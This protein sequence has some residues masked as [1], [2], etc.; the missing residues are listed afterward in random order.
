MTEIKRKSRILALI[1]CL[2]VVFSALPTVAGAA[3]D[4]FMFID[5]ENMTRTVNTAVIYRGIASTGQTQWGQSAVVDANGKITA[6]YEGGDASGG[7]IKLPEGGMVISSAGTKV[8]WMRDNLKVGRNVYY[9]GYTRRLFVYANGSDFDP[10][11][12]ITLD[13][14]GSDGD[15]RVESPGT[16]DSAPKIYGITVDSKGVVSARGSGLEIPEDGARI[17]AVD[18]SAMQTLIMYAPVGASCKIDGGKATVTL[19]KSMLKRVLQYA[20]SSAEAKLSE[21]KAEFRDADYDGAQALIDSA[22]AV[23]NENLGYRNTFE[24]VNALENELPVLLADREI[25]ELRSAVHTPKETTVSEVTAVINSAKSAG[26]NRII[27]RLT[28]GYGTFIPLPSDNKFK[29]DDKFGGFDVL[30]AYINNCKRN[31]IELEVCADVYY[32][33]YAAVAEPSWLTKSNGD[34]EG[35]SQKFF[36]PA[37][38]E[39]KE[40]FISYIEYLIGHYDIDSLTLDWARYPKFSESAD[41]GYDDATLSMFAEQYSV[42]ESEVNKLGSELFSNLHW[43][44][45]VEFRSGLVTD[46]VKSVSEKVR[47]MRPDITLTAVAARDNVPHY[48]MQNT[49][50]WIEQGLVDGVTLAFYGGDADENDDVTP[51]EYS[52]GIIAEKSELIAAYAG[53][54]AYFYIGVSS[55]SAIDANALNRVVAEARGVGADGLI[56]SDLG[57][58]IEQHYAESLSSGLFA[59][60]AVAPGGEPAESEKAILNYAKTKINDV[61]TVLNGCDEETAA[62]AFSA[63]NEAISGIGE[64]GLTPEKA[65][66]LESE[67]AMIFSRSDAKNAVLEDFSSL[68]KFA[69][70]SKADEGFVP[71]VPD[72]STPI[73]ESNMSEDESSEA[74][75]SSGDES[76]MSN[77][78]PGV[79][80][81]VGRILAFSFVGLALLGSAIALIVGIRRKKAAKSGKKFKS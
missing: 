29:Q 58:V 6:V 54:K 34:G 50:D 26:L 44:D 71:V 70:L 25:F 19:E 68:A 36:S 42:S 2:A 9:D 23:L 28:N 41:L 32:N 51:T 20:V 74:E 7:D 72:I 53:K 21:A 67:L 17:S 64:K 15:Y 5:G 40:Y 31:G 76:E 38:A 8:Q 55:R 45:W 14:A 65:N 78:E 77:S 11:G 16:S 35:M 69:S 60:V 57:G 79:S 18:D 47:E 52:S 48:Y 13:I 39:F 22:N 75:E 66:E 56:F 49:S 30:Q 46:M 59:G 80:V 4:A 62:Q 27:L 1:A 73:E 43:S 3:G 24:A 63:I 33:E 81:D 61:I 37:N 12:S 10:Y